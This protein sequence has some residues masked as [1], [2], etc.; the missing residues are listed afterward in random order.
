MLIHISIFSS[1]M[2]KIFLNIYD[3]QTSIIPIM[4]AYLITFELF[5]K[6]VLVRNSI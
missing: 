2:S 3:D 1:K 4:C 6:E 5:L